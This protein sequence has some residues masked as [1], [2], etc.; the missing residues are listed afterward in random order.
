[1]IR[2]AIDSDIEVLAH[3]MGEL[4]YPTSTEEMEIRMGVIFEESSNHTYVFV[5]DNGVVG[6]IGFMHCY[7][8]ENSD[9]YIRIN[10]FVVD[11]ESRG[12]GIGKAL[13]RFAESWARESGATMVTLNSGNRTERKA[14]HAFYE[15]CGFEGN[16]TGFYKKL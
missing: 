12:I 1:M 2:K 15:R 14:A 3:L 4:G 10:G 6:M 8:Y 16:A 5:R 9:S 11:S 7:R 13:L